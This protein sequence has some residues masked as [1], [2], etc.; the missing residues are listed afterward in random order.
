M[1]TPTRTPTR[2]KTPTPT[3]GPWQTLG[4]FRI[5]FYAEK[6]KAGDV[7]LS[8]RPYYPDALTAALG[9]E[10]LSNARKITGQRWPVIRITAPNGARCTF[11]VND[12]GSEALEVDLPTETWRIFGYPPEQG[13]FMG[14]VE[15][16]LR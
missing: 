11:Q 7:T 16:Y 13:V 12:S 2:T 5:T 1:P 4:T 8:G 3:R 14:T 10:L 6:Y 15:V 9:P